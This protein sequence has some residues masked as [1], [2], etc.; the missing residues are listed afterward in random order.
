MPKQPENRAGYLALEAVGMVIT[1]LSA[2]AVIRGFF[3]PEYEPLWGIFNGVPGGLSGQM[4]LLAFIA[5]VGT[6]F[7]GW[8]HIRQEPSTERAAHFR[9]ARRKYRRNTGK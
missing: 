4:I 3:N 7:G 8:A 9:G 5:L 1:A 2:Q 6:V